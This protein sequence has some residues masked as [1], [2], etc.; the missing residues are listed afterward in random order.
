[1]VFVAIGPFCWGMDVTRDGAIKRMKTNARSE[2]KS[3]GKRFPFILFKNEGPV[4]GVGVSDMGGVVW[5]GPGRMVEV[6]RNA[7]PER[8]GA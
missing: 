8:K 7:M 1:M 3:K 6:E 4:D 2:D 5:S